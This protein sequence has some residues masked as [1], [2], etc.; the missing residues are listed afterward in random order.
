MKRWALV[1]FVPH[2]VGGAALAQWIELSDVSVHYGL[3]ELAGPHVVMSYSLPEVGISDDTPAYVFVRYSAD[4][5]A[6][7]R[8][9]PAEFLRGDGF[10]IVSSAGPKKI[11][12]WG[13]AQAPV[14]D[15]Q[16]TQFRV[17]AMR[18]AR[19][20]AGEFKMLSVPG[21]GYDES[22]SNRGSRMVPLFYI[23]LCETT[24]SMYVDFLNEMGANGMG[25]NDRMADEQ[26]CG[27]TQYGAAPR[28]RYRVVPGRENFPVTY[29]SWYAAQAFLKWCGLRLPTELEW[30]K[31]ILGGEY[32]DG[33][34]TRE[35]PNPMPDRFYPWGDD[36]PDEGGVYRCN[37][38]A[39][40]DGFAHTAPVGSFPADKGPYGT[41]DM[42]G[43]VAEWTLDWYTTAWHEGADG[44]RVVR[45]GSWTAFP[46]G[47][48]AVTQ[49][50]SL[51]INQ[52]SN[53]GFRGVKGGDLQV[54]E[55]RQ[56]NRDKLRP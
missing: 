35:K 45:G 26:R 39:G 3:S 55:D 50:T 54:K 13:I 21:G 27:I 28:F 25:W 19:V 9:L 2:L 31:A 10:D 30:E 43:N 33:D 20:P 16:Q 41:Y 29:V 44:Y 56:G 11:V 7:W 17:R 6:T 34:D 46:E 37:M 1:A 40:E 15:A 47:V 52:T 49:A 14:L 18:M 38:D 12:L 22:H 23:A 8:L 53:M 48:D 42:A 32:L 4:Q 51:P 36:E 5:G 24:I